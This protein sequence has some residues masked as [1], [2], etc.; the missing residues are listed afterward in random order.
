[1]LAKPSP[2]ELTTPIHP[3]RGIDG[4]RNLFCVHYDACLDEAVKQGWSSF[5]CSACG[6]SAVHPNPEEGI[7]T[8]AQQRRLV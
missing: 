6:L 1:V 7:E 8:Y 4:Q 3:E 5:C 2:T